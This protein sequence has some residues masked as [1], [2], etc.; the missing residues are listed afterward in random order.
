MW[1]EATLFAVNDVTAI[2]LPRRAT[3]SARSAIR[4]EPEG[5]RTRLTLRR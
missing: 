1:R 3:N 2:A 5:R 4:V